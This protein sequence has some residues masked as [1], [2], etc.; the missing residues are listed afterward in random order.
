MI[1]DKFYTNVCVQSDLTKNVT[2]DYATLLDSFKAKHY[3]L[4]YYLKVGETKEIQGWILHI[5][6]VISQIINVFEVVIPILCAEG[7]PFKIPKDKET[8]I[9]L[10]NGYLGVHK[11][12]KIITIYPENNE[13]AFTIAKKLIELTEPFKGPSIPTDFALG[14]IVYTRYGGFNPIAVPDKDGIN[15]NYI[16]DNTGKLMK[17]T[18]NI[19]VQL[20]KHIPWPF[21]EIARPELKP[22]KKNL[23]KIY[24]PIGKLK[25]D[26]RGNVYKAVYL[27]HIFAPKMCVIKEGHKY[28]L[29]ED[30]GRN[31]RDRLVWQ[32][33]NHKILSRSIPIPKEIELFFE[34]EETY[35]AIDYIEGCTFQDFLET[36]NF[37]KRTFSSLSIPTRID[38]LDKLLK[39]VSIIE[40]LHLLGYV[41]RDIVPGNFIIDKKDNVWLIDIELTYSIHQKNPNPPFELGTP[42]FMSPEQKEA[43]TP[44]E[45]E[46]IYALGALLITSLI[47]ISPIKFDISENK[48]LLENIN[49]FI[50]HK[51]VSSLISRCLSE[52]PMMRPTIKEIK[53]VLNDFKELTQT[54]PEQESILFDSDKIKER[55]TPLI[56]AALVGLVKSPAVILNNLW[57]S[58]SLN[59]NSAKG[60][61]Q[62]EYS[63]QTGVHHGIGGVL[64][65]LAR[66][67]KLGFNIE[68]VLENYNLGWKY[69]EENYINAI[70][71]LTPGLYTG[72]AGIAICL[73]EAMCSGLLQENEIYKQWIFQ[74]I[75]LPNSNLN[76][77]SGVAGQGVAV[78]QCSN[79]IGTAKEMLKQYVHFLACNQ[80]KD[81][82]WNI[83]NNKKKNLS[84]GYGI[85]GIIWFLLDCAEY[86]DIELAKE[87]AQRSINWLLRKTDNLNALFNAKKNTKG[88]VATPTIGDERKG[89]LLTMIK[90]Y[91]VFKTKFYKTITE[92]SL[93]N[94]HLQIIKS[95][96]TQ[97]TGLSGLGELYLEAWRAFQNQEWLERASWIANI[98]INTFHEK[99]DGSGHWITDDDERI[100]VD[101]MSGNCGIIHFLMKYIQPNDLGYRLLK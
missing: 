21:G 51:S 55:L 43:K 69:I 78:L 38:I 68:D 18:Y 83:D 2:D 27:K 80:N 39:I 5:S 7:V 82:S 84:F 14:N 60:L 62:K 97:E 9:N 52:E 65:L 64:Y 71:K 4:D 46:D 100:S 59:R 87:S 6:S 66:A 22:S 63:I 11:I 47:G 101:L 10:L 28:M 13:K 48:S 26:V 91:D 94:Y 81:G 67:K 40:N 1:T 23:N 12:G 72:S 53:E 19:P 92:N 90:A 77:A 20:P 45:K 58:R 25:S 15:E 31:I 93:R 44:T 56:N 37:N 76:I 96:F 85:T 86:C 50:T 35:L 79:Y 54:N 16:Y 17:D 73:S 30:S 49:F 61:L 95:D 75:N 99:N 57:C 3:T 70:P 36:I 74:C 42:G 34:E 33:E 32:F 8:S 98:F 41:H 29:S 24:R 89:I 88:D